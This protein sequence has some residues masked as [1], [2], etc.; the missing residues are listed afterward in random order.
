[1]PSQPSTDIKP[2]DLRTRPLRSQ[3]DSTDVPRVHRSSGQ[4][5]PHHDA[6]PVGGLQIVTDQGQTTLMDRDR[7]VKSRSSRRSDSRQM[8]PVE[9]LAYSIKGAAN[10][11]HASKGLLYNAIRLYATDPERGL[12]ARKLMGRTVILHSDL[13]DWLNRLPV[14]SAPS[15]AHSERAHQRW[16]A[17]Q[18][19]LNRTS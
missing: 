1:M 18:T 11:I 14:K 7:P 6:A 13:M 12:R 10:S 8:I 17:A 5:S 9:P 16:A 15:A 3:S 19:L 4:S 2:A